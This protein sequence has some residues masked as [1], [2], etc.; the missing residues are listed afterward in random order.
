[1]GEEIVTTDVDRLINILKIKKKI[2]LAKI[3]KEL[4]LQENI[5]QK[6]VDFLVEEKIITI[7]YTFSSPIISL[8]EDEQKKEITKHDFEIYKQRFL[9]EAKN[10]KQPPEQLWQQHIL[11]KIEAMNSFFYTEADKKG[12]RKKDEL[13]QQYKKRLIQL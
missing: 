10:K 8:I 5:V 9:K 4:G 3:S 12:L 7:E 13:W 11:E 2:D 6:W 1:M